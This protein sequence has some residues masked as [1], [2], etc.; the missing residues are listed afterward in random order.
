MRAKVLW[1][2][3]GVP[4]GGQEGQGRGPAAFTELAAWGAAAS[5]CTAQSDKVAGGAEARS[6]T[7]GARRALHPAREVGKH[8]G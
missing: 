2:W 6:G 8:P 3:E 4:A 5:R 7:Q 1:G